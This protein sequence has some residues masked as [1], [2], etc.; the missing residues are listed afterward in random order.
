[1][2]AVRPEQPE[3]RMTV[4]RVELGVVISDIVM[5]LIV[6]G[7]VGFERGVEAGQ[8][9]VAVGAMAAAGVAAVAALQVIGR[10]EDEVRAFEVIVFRGRVSARAGSVSRL[11]SGLWAALELGG[12]AGMGSSEQRR[13]GR[14]GFGRQC[15]GRNGG[16]RCFPAGM[17]RSLGDGVEPQDLAWLRAASEPL[18]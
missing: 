16:N 8:F 17:G 14:D 5:D 1:M 12:V 9:R 18:R 11:V 4:S 10:G 13:R 3:P 6:T 7:R 15:R 2:A